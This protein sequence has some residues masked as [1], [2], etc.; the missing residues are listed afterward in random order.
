MVGQR[1]E[2]NKMGEPTLKLPITKTFGDRTSSIIR[3]IVDDDD[4]AKM[5]DLSQKTGLSIRQLGGRMIKFALEHIELVE[6]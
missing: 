6:V 4:L 1:E 5:D 2:V 3:V